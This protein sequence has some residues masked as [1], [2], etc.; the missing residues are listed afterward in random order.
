VSP[1]ALDRGGAD[2]TLA[3]GFFI[4][5]VEAPV[6]TRWR[7]GT[8]KGRFR[9]EKSSRYV[10]RT[11]SFM[12]VDGVFRFWAIRIALA[13]GAAI[14]SHAAAEAAAPLQA[15]GPFYGARG[16]DNRSGTRA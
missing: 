12:G 8:T 13:S 6:R 1:D 15:T 16:S 2:D 14:L 7:I 11:S 9:Q 5:V 10:S 3:D 4:D